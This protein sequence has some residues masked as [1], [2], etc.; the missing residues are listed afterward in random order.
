MALPAHV[1][2]MHLTSSTYSSKDPVTTVVPQTLQLSLLITTRLH[3]VAKVWC[4]QF[5]SSSSDVYVVTAG[6][7]RLR[8]GTS[9]AVV[10]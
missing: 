1:T 8:A 9:M 7:A 3:I 4:G 5:V 2:H 10:C 6:S